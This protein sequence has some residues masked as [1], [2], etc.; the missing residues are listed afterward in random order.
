MTD[1]PKL[2]IGA[3]LGAS[4]VYLLDPQR[5]GRRRAMLRDSAVSAMHTGA[6]AGGRPERNEDIGRRGRVA[7]L[8]VREWDANLQDASDPIALPEHEQNK[9]RRRAWTRTACLTL[10]AAGDLRRLNKSARRPTPIRS[11]P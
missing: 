1:R 8:P 9:Q 7:F 5:G 6:D 4:L 11:L 2:L 3:G 10:T